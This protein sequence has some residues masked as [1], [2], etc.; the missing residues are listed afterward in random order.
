LRFDVINKEESFVNENG[1]QI[2]YIPAFVDVC[3]DIV[4]EKLAL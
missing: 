2:K 4:I 1:E 3:P